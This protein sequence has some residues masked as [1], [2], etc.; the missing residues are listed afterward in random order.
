MKTTDDNFLVVVA[1]IAVTVFA[2]AVVI[3]NDDF[4]C[5]DFFYERKTNYH[6]SF[7]S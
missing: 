2:I 3:M 4:N 7:Y 6:G 5:Q 1:V